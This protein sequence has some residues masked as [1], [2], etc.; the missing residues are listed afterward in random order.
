M[1]TVPRAANLRGCEISYVVISIYIA[2]HLAAIMSRKG[3]SD[4]VA[5]FN[6]RYRA[7]SD[8][9]YVGS[10]FDLVVGMT[11]QLGRCQLSCHWWQS[12]HLRRRPTSRAEG[13]THTTVWIVVAAAEFIVVMQ[14]GE[15]NE[16]PT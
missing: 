3:A 11:A 2:V 9:A 14:G 12:L 16:R 7:S 5:V 6:S 8:Q 13:E 4:M 1:T 15:I 10:D